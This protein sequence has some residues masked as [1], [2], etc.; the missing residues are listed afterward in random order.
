MVF[1]GR[2]KEDD[3]KLDIQATINQVVSTYESLNRSNNV[4]YTN[5]HIDMVRGDMYEYLTS[6]IVREYSNPLDVKMM[7]VQDDL[8]GD[9]MII[10]DSNNLSVLQAN[11]Y[12][13]SSN[14]LQ[15]EN[16]PPDLRM[17]LKK[18]SLYMDENLG[19]LAYQDTIYF[20]RELQ[21]SVNYQY[22]RMNDVCNYI[23][24]TIANSP[25]VSNIGKENRPL[26]K[27]EGSP[28]NL[29]SQQDAYKEIKDSIQER[30]GI[31]LAS[32]KDSR[33]NYT[34]VNFD[35]YM[36]YTAELYANYSNRCT[37]RDLDVFFAA[38]DSKVMYER[39]RNPQ[40]Y[41]V[42]NALIQ[43]TI[44][45]Y[46][47]TDTILE[48]TGTTFMM[49]PAE[50]IAKEMIQERMFNN[51][52]Q[53]NERSLDCQA[54]CAVLGAFRE[55]MAQKKIESGFDNK[56]ERYYYQEVPDFSSMQI[57]Y[58]ESTLGPA[59]FG[60]ITIMDNNRDIH[61]ITVNDR[62][63]VDKTV[64]TIDRGT[65]DYANAFKQFEGTY[66]SFFSTLERGDSLIY[67]SRNDSFSSIV[68]NN[69][70][71]CDNS[72]KTNIMKVYEG[73]N[74]PMSTRESL[75]TTESLKQLWYI[76]NSGHGIE[77]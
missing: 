20:D 12:D 60:E 35:E 50:S 36:N 54:F 52:K 41:E 2:K 62:S 65:I 59:T 19:T 64:E 23:D 57:G 40:S 43:H 47:I 30:F 21:G 15:M 49:R 53:I 34:S 46:G 18:A 27:V 74:V 24:S 66:S 33:V 77:M 58:S 25:L 63:K 55:D 5:G 68:L 38:I 61:K 31:S 8:A 45:Q 28:Y 75:E 9:I 29:I 76:E 69:G 73:E 67:M 14:V 39:V 42:D 72:I 70:D 37:S 71:G 1:F 17:R 7:R 16:C 48:N 51:E 3:Y 13:N 6:D 10:K 4:Q 22:L 56:R 11:N 26:Q 32:S 44:A